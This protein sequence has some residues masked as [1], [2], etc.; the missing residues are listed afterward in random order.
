[1][2]LSVCSWNPNEDSWNLGFE[3]LK[4]YYDEYG[5]CLVHYKYIS[6]GNFKLG[7]WVS[8]Q[9]KNKDNLSEDKKILLES[10]DYWV[11]NIY[12]D[13]WNKGFKKLQRYYDENGDCLVPKSFITSDNFKLAN[14]IGT[15]RKDRANLSKDKKNLLESLNGWS[16]DPR[17][18]FWQ[19]G[20]THLKNYSKANGNC[21]VPSKY[22][23]SNDFYLGIWVATQKKYIDKLSKE[24]KKLLETLSGWSEV[25][26]K[27]KKL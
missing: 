25:V 12:D 27:L 18:E 11:W 17:E 1:V 14:W 9:R 6:T 7:N 13:M 22:I 24:R 20:F 16:W 2:S 19:L 3:N 15:Q 23:S 10:L 5:D 8:R 4:Q 21:L 26:K